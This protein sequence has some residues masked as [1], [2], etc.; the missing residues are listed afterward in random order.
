MKIFLGTNNR[1]KILEI[2]KYL[3]GHIAI[4]PDEI[5]GYKEPVEDGKDFAENSKIKAQTIW[6]L[7]KTKMKPGDLILTDD[8]G[9]IIPKLEDRLGVKTKREMESWT[10]QNATTE[11]EFWRHISKIA[12]ENAEANFVVVI[13]IINYKGDAKQVEEILTGKIT[14]PRGNNGF[15]FDSILEYEGRTLAEMTSEEKQKINPR[16]K[17]IKKALF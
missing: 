8:S 15:A 9:I 14:E 2:I 5:Q 1:G 13:T 11:K 7:V 12:G 17:A 10:E 6:N 3:P 4:C 16:A